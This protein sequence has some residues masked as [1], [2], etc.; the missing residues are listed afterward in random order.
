MTEKFL[1][2]M[3]TTGRRWSSETEEGLICMIKV[4]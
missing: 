3:Y 1:T 4:E 2:I